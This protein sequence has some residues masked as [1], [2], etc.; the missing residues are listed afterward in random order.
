MSSEAERAIKN[1]PEKQDKILKLANRARV[2]ELL[3]DLTKH[4]GMQTLIAQVK[5]TVNGLN[6]E[7]LN[8]MPEL[9]RERKMA[10]R[11]TCEDFLRIFPEAEQNLKAIQAKLKKY[12]V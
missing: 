6:A 3:I 12:D 9:E 7:L 2:A 5:G 10:I 11:D 4:E 1:H 8:R